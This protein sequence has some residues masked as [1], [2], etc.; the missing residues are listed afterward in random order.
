[1]RFSSELSAQ[2]EGRERERAGLKRPLLLCSGLWSSA[3]KEKGESVRLQTEQCYNNLQI[4]LPFFSSKFH[5]HG[6][7]PARQRRVHPQDNVSKGPQASRMD[8]VA[9]KRS[10]HLL[11]WPPCAF[12]NSRKDY[13]PKGSSG[14]DSLKIAPKPPCAP[15]FVAKIEGNAVEEGA[16]VE[17]R[18]MSI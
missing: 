18:K 15:K 2:R 11:Y 13:F 17:S 6:L 3:R 12:I 5:Q 7:L 14:S 16:K 8:G 9:Q 1:M 10:N 4:V